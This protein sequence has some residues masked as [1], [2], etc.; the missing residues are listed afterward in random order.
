MSINVRHLVVEG[1]GEFPIDMLR[2]DS[3]CPDTENDSIAMKSI[4]PRRIHLRR[5]SI[6]REPSHGRWESFGWKVISDKKTP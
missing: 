1:R 2:Y 6:G 4:D 5:F 3:A